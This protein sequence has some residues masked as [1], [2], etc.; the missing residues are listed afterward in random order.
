MIVVTQAQWACCCSMDIFM[1]YKWSINCLHC[2]HHCSQCV[3]YLLYIQTTALCSRREMK[4]RWMLRVLSP[5]SPTPDKSWVQLAS[6]PGQPSVNAAPHT[7]PEFNPEVFT[8]VS[9][10]RHKQSTSP[11][12]ARLKQANTRTC[13]PFSSQAFYNDAFTKIMYH[14]SMYIYWFLFHDTTH[15]F[16]TAIHTNKTKLTTGGAKVTLKSAT[17]AGSRMPLGG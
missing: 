16:V 4:H 1:L 6:V 7:Q 11:Q 8:S 3:T 9:G 17:S 15:I 14:I 13:T 12:H 2:Y 10:H 5:I